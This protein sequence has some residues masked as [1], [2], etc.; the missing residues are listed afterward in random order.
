[1]QIIQGLMKSWVFAK[2]WK[3]E[4]DGEESEIRLLHF[5]YSKT[6]YKKWLGLPKLY[7]FDF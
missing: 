1:M 3:I 5:K 7:R 2:S 4:I 6:L